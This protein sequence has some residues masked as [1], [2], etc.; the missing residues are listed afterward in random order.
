[1]AADLRPGYL[2]Q[3]EQDAVVPGHRFRLNTQLALDQSRE[4]YPK[5]VVNPSAEHRYQRKP[6]ATDLVREALQHD[7]L[8]G[9][10]SR[11]P[12]DARLRPDEPAEARGGALVHRQVLE[13]PYLGVVASVGDL[14]EEGALESPAEAICDP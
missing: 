2:G 11:R 3:S 8:V 13:H 5:R 6:T 9:G 14:T 7:S 10:E 1:M 12:H 4:R